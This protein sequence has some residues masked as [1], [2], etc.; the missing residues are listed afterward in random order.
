[1]PPGNLSI[2]TSRFRLRVITSYRIPSSGRLQSLSFFSP[3]TQDVLF[4]KSRG[5][6]L[7]FT[8]AAFTLIRYSLSAQTQHGI[9]AEMT[10][11]SASMSN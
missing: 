9:P 6:T 3:S 11:A 7:P 4:P 1:M 2:D 8:E 10:A 5:L